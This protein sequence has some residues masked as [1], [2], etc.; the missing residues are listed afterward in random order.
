[1]QTYLVGGAV[2]D[3]LLGRPV[4]DQDWVVVGGTP[5]QMLAQGYQSV[6]AD[7]PVF[8]HPKTKEEYALAR[9]ERKIG[10]GYTGFSCDASSEV[11]L[12]D[13]LMRRDLTINAMAMDDQGNI[14]DPYNGQ[15]DLKDKL[16]RHVSDAFVEDPLRVLRVAR[17]AARYHNLGFSIAPETLSLMQTI[18]ANDELTALSAERVWQ[19]TARS[20]METHPEVYFENLRACGALAVW[21]P[22]LDVLWGIPNPPKWHPEIDTGIHTMM[23]LQQAVKLSDKLSVRFAALV[24]D[25]GKGV[26]PEENWPS[27]RGHETL[28]LALVNTLCDRLKAPNECREL[29]LMVSEYHTHIHQA[30]ELKAS[31]ILGMLNRCDVWRKPQRFADLLVSCKADARGRTTFENCEYKNADYIWQAYEAAAKVDVKAIVAKGY[32]GK[33]IKQQTEQQRIS[34]IQAFKNTFQK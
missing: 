12:E 20:L 1:M 29:G 34:L 2:R 13:D 4:K 3:K 24:H 6:G 16:L 27:H 33:A 10:V 7:F 9:I 11:S 17:F 22:E 25:L 28:G 26:P 21:F 18:V 15:Q 14:I 8:L 23:V 19:E 32:Q 30:F 31:T 5:E